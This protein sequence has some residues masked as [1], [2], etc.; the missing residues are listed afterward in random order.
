M[1]GVKKK[2]VTDGLSSCVF[3]QL[4]ISNVTDVAGSTDKDTPTVAGNDPGS[5]EA[6]GN[7]SDSTSRNVVSC[8]QEDMVL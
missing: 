8:R 4:D 3:P 5:S 1:L 6:L 2:R 7:V